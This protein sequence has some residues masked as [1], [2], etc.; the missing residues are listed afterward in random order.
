MQFASAVSSS[1]YQYMKCTT[2]S[3]AASRCAKATGDTQTCRK[4]DSDNCEQAVFCPHPETNPHLICAAHRW[5][6]D[7]NYSGEKDVPWLQKFA[8]VF[9]D[10][11]SP[12][13]KNITLQDMLRSSWDFYE[14][15]S[16]TNGDFASSSNS[17]GGFHLPVCY[18]EG[19]NIDDR[20]FPS[21]CG[22]DYRAAETKD[23][24]NRLHVGVGSDAWA[25]RYMTVGNE[26]FVDRIPQVSSHLGSPSCP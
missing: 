8:S 25:R 9:K 13:F 4:N 6:L 14:T 20:K 18:S 22:R 16:L 11:S 15:T 23:F 24:M 17:A 3:K 1:N 19:M 5:H 21:G 26:L 12:I 7:D 2:S 10:E